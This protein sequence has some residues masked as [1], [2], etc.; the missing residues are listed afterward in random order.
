MKRTILLSALLCLFAAPYYSSVSAQPGSGDYPRHAEQ[1]LWSDES[2]A[3][4]QQTTYTYTNWGDV[5]TELIEYANISWPN[6]KRSYT[7][8]EKKMLTLELGQKYIASQWV[9]SSR[10]RYEYGDQ[11]HLLVEY[12]ESWNGTQWTIASATKNEYEFDGSNIIKIT[13]LN[14]NLDTR[15]FE[16]KFRYLYTL[17]ESGQI[18]ELDGQSYNNGEWVNLN[19]QFIFWLNTGRVDY[20]LLDMWQGGDW[21]HMSKMDWDYLENGG[22][23]LTTS[24]WDAGSQS[25]NLSIRIRNEFDTH[26]NQTLA[27]T[28]NYQDGDWT[29]LTSTQMTNTYN[30]NHLTE[31]V[32]DTWRIGIPGI[33]TGG[34]SWIHTKRE[35][36][37]DF[38][39]MGVNETELIT[40]SFDFFPNPATDRLTVRLSKQNT[41]PVEIL[42]LNLS[43]QV[44]K[45][46]WIQPGEEH[47][48]LTVSDLDPGYYLLSVQGARL[49][50]TKPLIIK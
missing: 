38:A 43:G 29:T 14:Y 20:M 21:I 37:S 24:S 5:E 18:I 16:Y 45:S 13:I 49:N 36:F 34:G 6:E 31:Q 50:M 35:L 30:N 19:R 40:S 25:Y 47:P 33:K 11:G 17:N 23:V 46:F 3:Q 8:D 9:N 27:L 1:Y 12:H 22:S 2:W 42:I 44:L 41:Q 32:T 4:S 48:D 7:Y 15:Q 10:D 39:T 26:E 28:Q